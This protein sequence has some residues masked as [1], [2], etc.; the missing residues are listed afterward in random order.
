MMRRR[1][2][3][4]S[5]RPLGHLSR[6]SAPPPGL[7]VRVHHPNVPVPLA[8]CASLPE[9][10]PLSLEHAAV[11]CLPR[12]RPLLSRTGLGRLT[13]S[14]CLFC[15]LPLGLP[16]SG[17]DQ[18]SSSSGDRKQFLSSFT[19]VG[20]AK[21]RAPPWRRRWSKES[22]SVSFPAALLWNEKPP[23]PFKKGSPHM[24]SNVER[25]NRA[26]ISTLK[27]QVYPPENTDFEQ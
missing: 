21:R 23:S 1:P 6:P 20:V 26:H 12:I 11:S 8:V 16:S 7:P 27:G 25:V 14:R 24:T 3:H 9:G 5:R 17:R 13:Q 18:P 19:P 15:R 4:T 22:Q 10:R 2:L